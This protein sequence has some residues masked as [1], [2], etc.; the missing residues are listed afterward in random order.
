M[1]KVDLLD[2][3]RAG[4]HDACKMVVRTTPF[5]VFGVTYTVCGGPKL[6]AYIDVSKCHIH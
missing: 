4:G 5:M 6:D 1:A 3:R 2:I